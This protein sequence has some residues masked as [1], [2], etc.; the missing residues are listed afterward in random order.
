MAELGCS[1]WTRVSSGADVDG[2]PAP[3]I[4]ATHVCA[5]CDETGG[6]HITP[7]TIAMVA[8]C[9]QVLPTNFEEV[10]YAVCRRDPEKGKGSKL[11]GVSLDAPLAVLAQQGQYFIKFILEVAAVHGAVGRALE[12]QRALPADSP[13]AE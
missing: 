11:S 10:N 2:L 4:H 5:R 3:G 1:P 13:V 8:C 7:V 12:P 9:L 6:Y